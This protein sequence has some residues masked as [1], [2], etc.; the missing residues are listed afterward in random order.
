MPLVAS[1]PLHAPLAL[2]DVALREVQ[3]R[4]AE[5]PAFIVV[6]DASKDTLGAGSTR[7]SPPPHA[8]ATRAHPAIKSHEMER[9][10]IP[11][12]VF[13]IMIWHPD[14]CL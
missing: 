5:L 2:H 7:E 13:V 12:K 4:V 8:E 10:D 6:D 3:V 9:T 1:V 14:A 11:G